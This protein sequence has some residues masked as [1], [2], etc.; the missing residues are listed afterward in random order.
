M[1]L[2]FCFFLDSTL[3]FCLFIFFFQKIR[4]AILN[5]SIFFCKKTKE[6]T[7]VISKEFSLMRVEYVFFVFFVIL[8]FYIKINHTRVVT[9]KSSSSLLRWAPVL[10]IQSTILSLLLFTTHLRYKLLCILQL[11]LLLNF[12]FCWICAFSSA[13]IWKLSSF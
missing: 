12:K 7:F 8:W 6:G 1:Q 13:V 3:T 4:A 5:W 10:L 11:A 2:T 9:W